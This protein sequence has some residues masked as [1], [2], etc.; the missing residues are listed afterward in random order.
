MSGVLCED[1][2]AG[3]DVFVSEARPGIALF[4]LALFMSVTLGI[5]RRAI[6]SSVSEIIA[7]LAFVLR[8]SYGSVP[9]DGVCIGNGLPSV[10]CTRLHS[11]QGCSSSIAIRSIANEILV[12]QR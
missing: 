11:P 10:R 1:E 9:W 2:I 8:R 4:R 5:A 3:M 6:K 12:L 7:I